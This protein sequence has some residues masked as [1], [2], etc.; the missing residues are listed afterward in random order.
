[1]KRI[2]LFTL[3]ILMIGLNYAQNVS[4]LQDKTIGGNQDEYGVRMDTSNNKLTLYISSASSISGERAISRRGATDM[5][6]LEV[7]QSSFSIT[8]QQAIGGDGNDFLIQT[9]IND[10]FYFFSGYTDSGVALD[11]TVSLKSPNGD[12]WVVKTDSTFAIQWQT[13]FSSVN[14]QSGG[15]IT[16]I[17][18]NRFLINTSSSSPAGIDKTDS[19][20]GMND[21]WIIM[22]DSLGN[23]LWDKT[24]GGSDWDN[25]YGSTY[26]NQGNIYLYG[27]SKSPVS[28]EKTE[29]AFDVSGLLYDFW[30]IKIDT[31][32]NILWDKTYGGSDD[33]SNGNLIIYNNRILCAVSSNSDISG[34]KT[35]SSFGGSDIWVFEISPVDGTILTQ[36][37]FGGNGND[38]GGIVATPDSMLYILARSTSGISG[39]K[40]ENSN[41][42][43]DIWILNL[44][45][46]LNILW[47]KDIGGSQNEYINDFMK[48]NS[49]EYI[50]ASTSNSNI[51]GDKTENSRGGYDVW[52]ITLNVATGIIEH[53]TVRLFTYPNPVTG[54]LHLDFDYTPVKNHTVLVLYDMQGKEVYRSAAEQYNTIDLSKWA[55]GTYVVQV[56]YNNKPVMSKK[57]IKQ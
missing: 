46:G 14:G 42:L 38:G 31:L 57:I 10:N 3:S 33:E 32:G 47:Q 28:G 20:R 13:A 55:N 18:D 51:S 34:N 6:I 11:K 24:Y 22:I 41:G 48:I 54:I 49:N 44:D 35:V 23:K 4:I 29:P 50:I 52:L 40:T 45:S 27:R 12:I 5:W 1:M 26:D 56:L 19:S 36:K 17:T 16:K 53:Q 9:K 30:I 7:N 21:Y 8:N 15:N 37:A 43:L 2:V 25:L 39:N